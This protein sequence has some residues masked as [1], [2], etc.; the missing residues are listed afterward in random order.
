MVVADS[1]SKLPETEQSN[2]KP[3]PRL[4][5]FSLTGRESRL[6]DFCSNLKDFLSAPSVSRQ[7]APSSDIWS[8]DP[9]FARVEA[10]SVS[11]HVMLFTLI[12]SPLIP[13]IIS[14]ATQTRAYPLTPFEDISA[15]FRQLKAATR[16]AGGGGGGGERNPVPA[17]KGAVPIFNWNPL[18][19]PRVRTPE[20]PIYSVTPALLG[21]PELKLAGPNMDKWGHPIS[22]VLN[23]SGGPGGANGIGSGDG[24]GIGNGIG[25]GL[26]QGMRWGAGDGLPSVGQPGY[27]D[28]VCDYCPSAQFS[29]EAVKAKYE[30]TVFL[31]II[32]TADGR[33]ADV[34]VSKGLGLGLDEEAIEAVRKWRFRPSRGPDGKPTAVHATV[35]VQF[36]LY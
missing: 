24:N 16:R 28:I 32:V 25:D 18:A 8:K 14:P 1:P 27:S 19:P 9:Q 20:N 29:D 21:P 17:S 4:R 26:G 31:S 23:D 13:R 5:L 22:S 6:K 12:V 15:Y 35:E 11:I 7:S 10:L 3:K 30:G 33:V 36:H 34:H 2:G